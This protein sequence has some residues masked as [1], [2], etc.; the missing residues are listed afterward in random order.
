MATQ[1][2]TP[3]GATGATPAAEIAPAVERE[4]ARWLAE[5][6]QVAIS[7]F[8]IWELIRGLGYKVEYEEAGPVIEKIDTL[9]QVYVEFDKNGDVVDA[10]FILLPE[11]LNPGRSILEAIDEIMYAAPKVSVARYMSSVADAEIVKNAVINELI[12][13]IMYNNAGR[14]DE[15]Y[16]ESPLEWYHGKLCMKYGVVEEH[17]DIKYCALGAAK[18]AIW[19][20]S[21][22]EVVY[23]RL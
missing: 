22:G 7:Y 21:T 4:V 15:E 20:K 5:N 3:A 18:F 2:S 11:E 19:K 14:M 1:N 12:S 16:D 13:A 23:E 6:N 10:K 8:T 17:G 9:K